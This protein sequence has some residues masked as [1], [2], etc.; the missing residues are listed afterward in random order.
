LTFD[1]R[2]GILRYMPKRSEESAVVAIFRALADPTRLA[3]VERLS[4]APASA[5]ELARPFDMALPSFMQHLQVL[6]EAAIVSSHKT[7]RTRIYQLAPT[8]LRV[9][10]EWLGTFRNHWDR[11]LDQLEQL[12][13]PDRST[14]PL[15]N[16]PTTSQH[17][18]NH[19][20]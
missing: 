17:D 7:G 20:E 18:R 9:A 19:H 2:G 3:V 14:Q 8:T 15:S 6:E 4:I 11:R 16:S 1:E 5:S 10:S 13:Q 12:L